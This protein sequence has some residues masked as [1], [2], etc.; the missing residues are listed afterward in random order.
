MNSAESGRYAVPDLPPTRQIARRL[1]ERAGVDGGGS[2]TAAQAAVVACDHLY[3]ELSRWVG[4]DGCHALFTRALAHAQTD[5]P[6]LGEIQL[7][8][9]SEP[10]LAGVAEVVEAYGATATA[11]ALESMLVGLIELLGRL[12]GDDMAMKM[13]EGS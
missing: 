4:A 5:H 2:P 3:Q 7:R 6:L 8:A 10:Y 11:E 12:V 9:R 1:I 13:I